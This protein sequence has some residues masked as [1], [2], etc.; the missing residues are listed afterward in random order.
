[1]EAEARMKPTFEQVVMPILRSSSPPLPRRFRI[2]AFA[3]EVSHHVRGKIMGVSSE[4]PENVTVIIP[5]LSAQRLVEQVRR[6]EAGRGTRGPNVPQWGAVFA[7]DAGRRPSEKWKDITDHAA[8]TR[9]KPS[10]PPHSPPNRR[11]PSPAVSPNLMKTTPPTDADFHSRSL[12]NL[13]REHQ[14]TIEPHLQ[15]S[16]PRSALS[17]L[18]PP[19]FIGFR[20]G[21]YLQLSMA[22]RFDAPSGTSR[23]KLAALAFDEQISHLVRP[24]LDYF[25]VR[26]DFDGIDFSGIIHLSAGS[27]S[28]R[29]NSFSLSAPCVV[30]PA[31]TA[32]VSNCSTPE[33]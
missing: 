6:S 17:Y 33:R 1:M 31:T 2:R 19:R 9:S 15:E 20:Q 25:P 21:A 18:L 14:D 13:Q 5:V 22:T 30:S 32:P 10:K 12:T 26:T 4:H 3:I 8:R 16:R 23:Y 7:M 28:W 27:S 24:M 29:L 11:A